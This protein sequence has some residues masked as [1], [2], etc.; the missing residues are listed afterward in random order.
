MKMWAEL[1]VE[2]FRLLA[3]N[4]LKK[5]QAQGDSCLL[6]ATVSI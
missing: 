5:W 2:A 3:A 4:P 6:T 1:R